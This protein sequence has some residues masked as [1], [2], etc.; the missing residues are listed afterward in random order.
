LKHLQT[1]SKSRQVAS[2]RVPT[3]FMAAKTASHF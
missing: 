1:V 3:R 2:K